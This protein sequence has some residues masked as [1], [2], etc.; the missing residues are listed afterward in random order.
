MRKST[1]PCEEPESHR[2]PTLVWLSYMVRDILFLILMLAWLFAYR[3]L[4]P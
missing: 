4:W 2:A 3:L 1:E